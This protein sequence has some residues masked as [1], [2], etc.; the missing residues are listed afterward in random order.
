MLLFNMCIYICL[1]WYMYTY[2]LLHHNSNTCIWLVIHM[3]GMYE[4][5]AHYIGLSYNW[6]N[7]YLSQGF[8]MVYYNYRGYGRS[9]GVPTPARLKRDVED[10]MRHVKQYI[11]TNFSSSS[12][13]GSGSTARGGIGGGNSGGCS[14]MKMLI[15]GESL[16]G[17]SA[18]HIANIYTN[19]SIYSSDGSRSSGSSDVREGVAVKLLVCDRTFA[20]LDSVAARMLGSWAGHALR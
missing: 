11:Q 12:S 5:M 7:F 18:C 8:N 15:H 20:S 3:L 13:S 10:V 16:G 4:V 9:A 1:Y 19:K 6:S 17:M 2:I 14:S